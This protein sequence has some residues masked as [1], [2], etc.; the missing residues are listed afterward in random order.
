MSHSP[1]L[2][3]TLSRVTPEN[4]VVLSKYT[5][6]SSIGWSDQ[7]ELRYEVHLQKFSLLL[8]A[9]NGTTTL[10]EMNHIDLQSSLQSDTSRWS[11]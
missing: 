5:S 9:Q 6:E 10:L 4:A 8:R 7:C 1:V 11:R 3:I 2:T